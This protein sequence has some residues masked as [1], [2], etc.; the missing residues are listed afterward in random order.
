MLGIGQRGVA[1]V[2]ESSAAHGQA[3]AQAGA[4]AD[5]VQKL[6]DQINLLNEAKTAQGET[7]AIEIELRD[8]ENQR[9]HAL[10]AESLAL[11][12]ARDGVRAF[13]LDMQADAKKTSQI[14]YDTLNSAVDRVS[15]NAAKL[16][17]GQKTEWGKR[18]RS[19]ART[20]WS[21][22]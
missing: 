11:G 5:R 9:L 14:V 6:Q 13:F 19:W 15:S 18:F 7:L 2:G 20:W 10:A 22:L 16:L 4:N 12:S 1:A 3:A 21:R 8:L 17:T